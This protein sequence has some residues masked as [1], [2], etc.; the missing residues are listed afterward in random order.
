MISKTHDFIMNVLTQNIIV[1]H[2]SNAAQKWEATAAT[3]KCRE[4]VNCLLFV[5]IS[6]PFKL[7]INSY[8]VKRGIAV[9]GEK[10]AHDVN[11]LNDSGFFPILLDRLTPGKP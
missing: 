7:A 3:Q 9:P 1:T 8:P 2:T 4:K 5:P 10:S 6:F 11:H